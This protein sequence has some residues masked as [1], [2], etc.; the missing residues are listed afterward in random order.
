MRQTDAKRTSLELL[1]SLLGGGKGGHALDEDTWQAVMERP[2]F[3]GLNAEERTRLRELATKLLADKAFSGADDLQV[4]DGMATA[5]AAFAALPVLNIGYGWYE[6][7]R[8]IVVYPGE[9]VYDGE[10][11][12]EAGV[13]HHVRHV[14]SGEAM[15]GGPMVLSWQD[16]E[17]SGLGEGFNVVIHEFAHKLDMKNG[18]ANGRPPLH[19]GISPANWARD[20]QAAYDDLC[21]RVDNGEETMIDPYATDSPAEFFA[22][23]SEYFFEAPDVLQQEYL[24]VYGQLVSFYK[25]DPLA[26]LRLEE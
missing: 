10:Q 16:V 25:Q 19:S 4:D 5:I 17:Y 20:F 11:M 7:W 14:R 9:Y 8:E 2:V 6:G 26:R 24:A 23:L 13:V 21:H 1:A 18:E 3:D 12:D 15:A 22:V